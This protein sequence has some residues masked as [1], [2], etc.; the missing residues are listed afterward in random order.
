MLLEMS[1]GIEKPPLHERIKLASQRE[2]PLE[3]ALTY[4]DLPKVFV[5]DLAR[6]VPDMMPSSRTVNRYLLERKLQ[7]DQLAG[8]TW[9]ALNYGI[10]RDSLARAMMRP[11]R[12]GTSPA[13]VAFPLTPYGGTSDG[14]VVYLPHVE[15][16]I[17]GWLPRFKVWSKLDSYAAEIGA[18]L[19]VDVLRCAVSLDASD[20]QPAVATARCIASWDFVALAHS[21]WSAVPKLITL[22]PDRIGWHMI[23]RREVP[24]EVLRNADLSR[25]DEYYAAHQ[26]EASP[27]A[28]P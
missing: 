3:H 7:V 18:A 19:G 26:A 5:M 17:R 20:P 12:S 8:L 22:P 2:W 15:A 11:P 4:F 27:A 10:E 9:A 16:W 1:G 24:R 28:S 23:H 14:Y 21:E 6:A 13:H 25:M